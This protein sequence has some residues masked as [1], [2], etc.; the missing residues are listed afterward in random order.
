MA[1]TLSPPRGDVVIPI[2]FYEDP[3]DGSRPFNYVASPPKGLPQRNFRL[4]PHDTLLQD[5]RGR[6]GH[7][8]S[9]T[10]PPESTFE[11]DDST[12]AK[13]YP[14]VEQLLLSSIPGATRVA[15]FDHT[16]R[17]AGTIGGPDAGNPIARAHIDHT[18][19]AAEER[20]RQTVADEADELLKGRWRIVNVWR[21]LNKEPLENA[22]LCFAL[23]STKTLDMKELGEVESRFPDGYLG[24]TYVI[25]H[26]PAQSWYYLSGMTGND[27]LVIG[28]FDSNCIKNNLTVTG[29]APHTAF[30]DPRERPGAETRESIEIRALGF[31]P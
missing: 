5:V 23:A 10:N 15:I 2:N 4:V 24:Q 14:E 28:I 20:L 9:T 6:E 13:Y 18:G 25:K 12:R 3:E 1:T 17:R 11:N 30:V 19:W 8:R 31:G 16:L 21:P 27:R 29:G 22:P 7:R 26:N